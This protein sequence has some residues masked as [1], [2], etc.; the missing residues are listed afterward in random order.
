MSDDTFGYDDDE[1]TSSALIK[2]LRAEIKEAHKRNAELDAQVKTLEGSVKETELSKLFTKNEIPDKYQKLF[3]RGGYEPTE[4][5]MAE[6][7]EE[8][9]TEFGKGPDAPT[10]EQSATAD[11][12]KKMRE[13]EE[14]A[15]QPSHSTDQ[16]SD[17]D[18]KAMNYS[19]FQ[20]FI[21]SRGLN[22]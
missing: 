2:R 19:D 17:A 9:G 7:L 14:Q 4:E 16:I 12:L 5:G 20:K 11:A 10:E 21:Q 6:F 3:K 22:Q 18:L 15:R 1:D 8:W 13:A